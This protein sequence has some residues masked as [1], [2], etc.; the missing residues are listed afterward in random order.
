M[1]FCAIGLIAVAANIKLIIDLT[2]VVEGREISSTIAPSIGAQP[3]NVHVADLARTIRTR[4]TVLL[5]VMVVCLGSMIYLFVSRVIF[6]L[7]AIARATEEMAQG[8]L[9][10]TA[11]CHHGGEVG[12]LGHMI[13]NLAVNFQEVLLL[14][15]TVVGSSYAT[16]EKIQQALERDKGRD[17]DDVTEQVTALKQN[18]E[19]LGTMV[20]DFQFYQTRFDGQKVVAQRSR[21]EG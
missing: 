14:T 18:L 7:H 15:G 9:A 1:L 8:N 19:M 13:N 21:K 4:L 11:P 6:P 2:G 5:G 20:K 17:S 3:E 12:E 10:V 16:V